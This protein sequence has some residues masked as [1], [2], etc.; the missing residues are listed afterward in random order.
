MTAFIE[1]VLCTRLLESIQLFFF[2]LSKINI[3]KISFNIMSNSERERWKIHFYNLFVF[4]FRK[5]FPH[6]LVS[7]QQYEYGL[8]TS[9]FYASTRHWIDHCNSY[10][11]SFGIHLS[12]RLSFIFFSFFQFASFVFCTHIIFFFHFILFTYPLTRKAKLFGIRSILIRTHNNWS[13]IV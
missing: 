7:T 8:T 12:L 3:R 11:P 1:R 6:R 4:F 9:E 2:S 13:I 10:I 5:A